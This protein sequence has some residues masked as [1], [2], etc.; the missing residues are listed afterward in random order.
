[1]PTATK[2]G[3]RPVHREVDFATGTRLLKSCRTVAKRTGFDL[4]RLVQTGMA[5][6]AE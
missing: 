3:E 6:D 4:D 5:Q 1:M 2:L